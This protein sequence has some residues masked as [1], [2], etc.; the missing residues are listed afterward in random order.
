[1]IKNRIELA[2]HFANLGLSKGAEIGV[3]DGYYSEVLLKTIPNLL[4]LCCDTWEDG[5][6]WFESYGP[7][8]ELLTPYKKAIIYREKSVDLAKNIPDASLDFV[9]IDGE[10]SY[11]SVHEDLWAWTPKVRKG[12][13]I[14]G[15]DYYVT[16]H[17]NRGVV[18]AVDEF[19]KDFDYK[20]ELT[21]WDKT[22]PRKDD[23]QPC[24]FF[25]Q[26]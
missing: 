1:M 2:K 19:A 17:G 4:L 12:G 23:H 13:I 8:L 5:T 15:H 21:E 26:K 22:L 6:K 25:T 9:F 10:H 24:W 11:K 20:L 3:C 7:A 14:S 16:K 18:E